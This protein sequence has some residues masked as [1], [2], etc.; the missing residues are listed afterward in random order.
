MLYG[1]VIKEHLDILPKKY[2]I[3][4]YWKEIKEL[5]EKAMSKKYLRNQEYTRYIFAHSKN[6]GLVKKYEFRIRMSHIHGD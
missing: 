5:R 2:K 1:R 6:S 3:H 4:T